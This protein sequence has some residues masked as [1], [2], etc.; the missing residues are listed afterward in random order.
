M[1]VHDREPQNNHWSRNLDLQNFQTSMDL[2]R[3]RPSEPGPSNLQNLDLQIL[4]PQRYRLPKIQTIRTWTSRTSRSWI[5]RTP[6]LG[7][8]EIQNLDLQ[9]A[10]G[11]ANFFQVTQTNKQ[12]NNNNKKQE[13]R[14]LSI[15]SALHGSSSPSCCCRVPPLDDSGPDKWKER[16][17]FFL[18]FFFL[19]KKEGGVESRNQSESLVPQK[20][21]RWR[22]GSQ[23]CS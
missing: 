17:I 23:L 3:S 1:Y 13:M 10:A 11:C 5:F 19:T 16:Q 7:S 14:A 21:A 8:P 2:W 18:F 4:D 6:D 9:E 12:T 20:Q 22:C 15:C